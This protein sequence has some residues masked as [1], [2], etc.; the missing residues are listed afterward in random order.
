M[1]TLQTR[2]VSSPNPSLRRN[3]DAI[4]ALW[5]FTHKEQRQLALG[6]ANES[7]NLA[8]EFWQPGEQGWRP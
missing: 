4:I 3:Y 6:F 5:L 1:N 8:C 7:L 2:R